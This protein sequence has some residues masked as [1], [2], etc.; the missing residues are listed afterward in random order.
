MRAKRESRSLAEVLAIA[1]VAGSLCAFVFLILLSWARAYAGIVPVLPV[2]GNMSQSTWYEKML[3]ISTASVGV[4]VFAK[5]FRSGIKSLPHRTQ[6]SIEVPDGSSPLL[7][8]SVLGVITGGIA[9]CVTIYLS[10]CIGI[11]T[12]L[13]ELRLFAPYQ[14]PTRYESAMWVWSIGVAV[15]AFWFVFRFILISHHRMQ[16]A[17][18]GD[19]R[20]AVSE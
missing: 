1:L 17:A 6:S 2:T 3:W 15:L 10:A 12:G 18:N 4:L 14:P 11:W 8:A 16:R 19:S 13:I 9:F 20:G 7:A 5:V